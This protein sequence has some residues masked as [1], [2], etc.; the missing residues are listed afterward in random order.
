MTPSF[1]KLL[2]LAEDEK[3]ATLKIVKLGVR[4]PSSNYYQAY[5]VF[6]CEEFEDPVAPNIFWR[7]LQDF[8]KN[9]IDKKFAWDF[10]TKQRKM[11]VT[12]LGL[13]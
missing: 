4:V 12:N 3:E 11:I 10:K 7:A 2:A 6:C 5:I 9:K 1:D 8:F 13:K